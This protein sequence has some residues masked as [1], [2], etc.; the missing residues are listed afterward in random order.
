M[1]VAHF[2][3]WKVTSMSSLH[4]FLPFLYSLARYHL[5]LCSSPSVT[6]FLKGCDFRGN[7]SLNSKSSKT[8]AMSV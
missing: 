2:D 8:A 7:C 6:S 3:A 4:A 1:L 5:I